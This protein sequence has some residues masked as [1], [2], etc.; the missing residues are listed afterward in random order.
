MGYFDIPTLI[1]RFYKKHKV[2]YD[3]SLFTEYKNQRDKIKIICPIHGE[4]EQKITKHLSGQGCP[5]CAHN[6]KLTNE[7][8]I[9]RANKKHNNRYDYSKVEYISTDEKVKI[10]CPIHGEFEQTPHMHL[11]GQGCPKCCGTEKKTTEHFIEHC[12]QIH[13][14]FYDYS[15]VVYNGIYKKVKIICPIH[16]EFEQIARV[17]YNG[18]GC[19]K[20]QHS[21]LERQIYDFLKKQNIEFIEQKKFKWLG[22]QTLDFYLPK[23]NIAIECQGEQ[24]L[25]LCNNFGS[26]HYTREE[27]HK[28]I[29]D[30]DD[31]KNKLCS[32]NG[33]DILY[34]T[35]F[36][37]EYRYPIYRNEK[38]LL[39]KILEYEK[40]I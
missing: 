35:T 22:L 18:H 10:I 19:P 26:K 23:Y 24:H 37:Y 28:K 9:E 11:S 6:K 31:K 2:K 29:C 33:I 27:L 38:D 12:T 7:E 32:E 25:H 5:K 39:N 4:F 17:H 36:E 34:F 14:N 8:F 20:C 13:H 1:E 40:G 3:Y 30:L 16:G 21:S 15:K